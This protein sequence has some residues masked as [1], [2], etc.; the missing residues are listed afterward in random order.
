MVP[1]N[2]SFSAAL[3]SCRSLGVTE[4]HDLMLPALQTMSYTP[5]GYLLAGSALNGVL[6]QHRPSSPAPSYLLAY[7]SIH[8]EKD[9][10][11]W[12]P[13]QPE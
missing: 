5:H 9:V 1:L 3:I 11:N 2:L 4:G 6:S 12:S 8:L 10:K 13:D 7:R